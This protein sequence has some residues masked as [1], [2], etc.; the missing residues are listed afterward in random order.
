M[1]KIIY[2]ILIATVLSFGI[3]EVSAI[4][5][6][7]GNVGSKELTC[8]YGENIQIHVTESTVTPSYAVKGSN[9]IFKKISTSN[10]QKTGSGKL[11]LSC[12]ENIYMRQ[13]SALQDSSKPIYISFNLEALGGSNY[14]TISLDTSKSTTDITLGDSNNFKSCVYKSDGIDHGMDVFVQY[15]NGQVTVDAGSFPFN[16][17]LNASDFEK[18]GNLSCPDYNVYCTHVEY[19][20]SK[21]CNIVK[22]DSKHPSS[23]VEETL[24][25]DEIA[26]GK[27]RTYLGQLKVALKLSPNYDKIKNTNIDLGNGETTTINAINTYYGLCTTDDCGGQEYVEYAIEQGTRKIASYCNDI[28]EN[29]GK[30]KTKYEKAMKECL[31]FSDFYKEVVKNGVISSDLSSDCPLLSSDMIAKLKWVLNIFRIVAPLLAF[32]LGTIDFIKVIASGDADKEL[33][34]AGKRLLFRIIAAVLLLVIPTI[35]AFILDVFLGNSDGYDSD[36]PFCSI[37]EWKE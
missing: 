37:V 24:T 20:G 1:K 33:K 7:Q 35:L 14:Q 19:S 12:P 34:N 25:G 28:Y 31:G 26:N 3:Q 29:Y 22:A 36:N 10:F 21:Q 6:E 17:T 16:G 32:G 8:V 30:D 18:D 11:V 15:Y 2:S 13:V 5:S 27:Y 9:P 4:E 23:E